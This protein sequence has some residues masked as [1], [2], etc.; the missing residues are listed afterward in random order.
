VFSYVDPEMHKTLIAN[1]KLVSIGDT[2]NGEPNRNG[3]GNGIIN[4]LG[5]IPLPRIVDDVEYSFRWYPFVRRTEHE[6]VLEIADRLRQRQLEGLWQ[7]LTSQ[8]TVNSLLVFGDFEAAEAPLV[9]VHSCCITGETFGSMRCECGPQLESAF[10]QIIAEGAGA[11]VYMSG[12]EGR[13][14]GLWAKGITYLLQD[15]GQDTYDAN[16][17]LNLPDDSRDFGD[18]AIVLQH[19][20]QQPPRVRLLSNNPLKRAAL[21]DNGIEVASVEQ[22]LTGVCDHNLRYLRAKRDHGHTLGELPGDE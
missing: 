9:R 8:M 10:R 4:L 14:I 7:L 6:Q 11:I 17:S 18:A 5:P 22:I 3:M 19:F 20:L 1:G 13:G 21:S 2:G 12:H 15:M 16:R